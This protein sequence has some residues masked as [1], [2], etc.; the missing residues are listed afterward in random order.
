MSATVRASTQAPKLTAEQ[1]AQLE[2]LYT[3]AKSLQDRSQLPEVVHSIGQDVAFMLGQAIWKTFAQGMKGCEVYLN[4]LRNRM[5]GI[6]SPAIDCDL[7][8]GGFL[9]V[10]D[11]IATT[12]LRECFRTASTPELCAAFTKIN[13]SE[14]RRV[15]A[16]REL[17]VKHRDAVYG[18]CANSP[19]PYFLA[20][21]EQDSEEEMDLFIQAGYDL[22]CRY[23]TNACD[24]LP[25]E[26][27]LNRFFE[28]GLCAEE[29]KEKHLNSANRLL[30]TVLSA[31]ADPNVLLQDESTTEEFL[32]TLLTSEVGFECFSLLVDYGMKL[33]TDHTDIS[34]AFCDKFTRLGYGLEYFIFNGGVFSEEAMQLARDEDYE[35]QIVALKATREAVVK[36]MPLVTATT[37]SARVTWLSLPS[38]LLHVIAA[39]AAVTLRDQRE[40][41]FQRQKQG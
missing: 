11:R 9:N 4:G 25:L 29:R 13:R 10:I 24:F 21:C 20:T 26:H 37:I 27:I 36:E 34:M 39:F 33:H 17:L 6:G 2:R 31:G 18:S 38:E 5:R 3:T 32:T 8:R 23:T 7:I 12:N 41:C 28:Y 35:Q 19:H 22:N 1:N 14:G 40:R 30:V 16:L 15:V